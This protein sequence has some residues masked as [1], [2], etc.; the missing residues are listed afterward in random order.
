MTDTLGHLDGAEGRSRADLLP[1]LFAARVVLAVIG[2]GMIFFL[3]QWSSAV[4]REDTFAPQFAKDAPAGTR[5]VVPQYAGG[6]RGS[7]VTELRPW[8]FGTVKEHP[9]WFG[10]CV[11]FLVAVGGGFAA[12]TWWAGKVKGEMPTAKTQ[13]GSCQ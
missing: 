13:A 3:M 11:A 7:G 6:G 12:C 5:V 10:A 8:R 1:W 9:Y 4:K 2:V